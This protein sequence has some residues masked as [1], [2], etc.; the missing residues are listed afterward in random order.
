MPSDDGGSR[1]SQANLR[2]AASSMAA[3]AKD[4]SALVERFEMDWKR[5]GVVTPEA[6]EEL[7]GLVE[8]ARHICR[9]LE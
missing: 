3:L 5:R 6:A 1:P 8:H 4:L 7:H 2:N 9:L